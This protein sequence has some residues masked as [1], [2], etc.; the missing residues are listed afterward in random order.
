M[1]DRAATNTK[2]NSLLTAY[3]DK[4][5]AATKEGWSEMSDGERKVLSKLNNHFCALHLLVNLAAQCSATLREFE[6]MHDCSKAGAA[7]LSRSTVNSAEPGALRLVR[8][9][10]KV[11]EKH[12][13]EKA[14]KMVE[15]SEFARS[16]GINSLPLTSY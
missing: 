6:A 8:T 10:C 4:I 7:L 3:R 1:T 2:F 11:F 9:A 16:K 13:S 5:L 14:G 12:G 15:F